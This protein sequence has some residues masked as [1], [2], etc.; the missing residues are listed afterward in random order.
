[1]MIKNPITNRKIKINGPTYNRLLNKGWVLSNKNLLTSGPLV[2]RTTV[3]TAL[4]RD[5][6]V[7]R[8]SS[9][10]RDNGLKFTSEIGA[11]DTQPEFVA[12]VPVPKS[13]H[14]ETHG[15]AKMVDENLQT[16]YIDTDHKYT[17]IELTGVAKALLEHLQAQGVDVEVQSAHFD[18]G[19]E[20]T[21][22]EIYS[23]R[24][25]DS[26][27][28]DRKR[29]LAYQR[30]CELILT[31][32]DISTIFE[33]GP[34][35]HGFLSIMVLKSATRPLTFIGIEAN[36]ESADG[37]TRAIQKFLDRSATFEHSTHIIHGYS[38]DKKV[39][40]ELMRLQSGPFD[41]MI[42]EIFGD[43]LSSE[44]FPYIMN[45]A[46][47]DGL[48]QTTTRIVPRFGATL[49]LPASVS[50]RRRTKLRN[51][52]AHMGQQLCYSE[53]P[54][55]GTAIADNPGIL[56]FYDFQNDFDLKQQRSSTFLCKNNGYLDSIV[57]WIW[58]DMGVE[59]RMQGLSAHCRSRFLCSYLDHRNH[60]D[61]PHYT[62]SELLKEEMKKASSFPSVSFTSMEGTSMT[63]TAW[64]RPLILLPRR[65]QVKAGDQIRIS[66][67]SQASLASSY[68]FRVSVNNGDEEVVLLSYEDIR[69]GYFPI[70][71]CDI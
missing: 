55:H 17:C 37:A 54:V 21:A 45:Q 12:V 60:S 48:I 39:K 67:E 70:K 69:P 23:Y 66:T 20:S 5:K 14:G 8:R 27:L 51:T 63:T 4:D 10:K 24:G 57:C 43:F 33:I 40:T 34:G 29:N 46:R 64:L 59:D 61:F 11:S 62:G 36:K 26:M 18:S 47:Q 30:A 44:A 9:T 1:M 15:D 32:H 3:R 38:T 6:R 50:G 22:V 28:R 56:E 71:D 25:Y 31:Q 65:I 7:S 41:V 53:L 19:D 42:S 2:K 13:S 68:T 16:G 52:T 49:Y 35:V 58:S